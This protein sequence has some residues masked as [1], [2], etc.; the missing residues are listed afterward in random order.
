[1]SGAILSPPTVARELS[2]PASRPRPGPG[3]HEAK[4]WYYHRFYDF[5]PDLNWANPAVREEIK[6]VMGFWLQLGAAGFRV[7]AAPFVLEQTVARCQPGAQ[8]LHD[9]R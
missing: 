6:K 2:S 8:G 5:Q 4:A 7:D 3:N 9:P 1:M